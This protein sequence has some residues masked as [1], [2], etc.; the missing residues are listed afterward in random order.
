MLLSQPP[1]NLNNKEKVSKNKR[2][3]QLTNERESN[4]QSS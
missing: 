1:E 4:L 2:S 3:P